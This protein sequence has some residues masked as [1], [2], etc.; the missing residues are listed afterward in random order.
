MGSILTFFA[1]GLA[2]VFADKIIGYLAMKALLVFLFLVAV[3]IL[4]NNFLY[5]IIEIVMNFASSQATAN[6]AASLNGS[7]S[8]TGF[9]AYLI[10]CFQLP[11]ALS[12]MVSALILRLCLSMIPF[13]RL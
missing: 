7:L 11:Q 13:I 6:G 8:F 2:K 9:G 3:P 10:D 4:L 5:D 1:S 12:V